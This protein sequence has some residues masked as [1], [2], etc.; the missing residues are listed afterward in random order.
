VDTKLGIIIPDQEI[1]SQLSRQHPYENWLKENRIRLRDIETPQRVPSSVGDQFEVF[2]NAF[3][4]NKDDFDQIV[5]PMAGTANEP[6]G[7]MGNDTPM[8]AFSDKPQRLFSYFRQL[9]AQ[10]TNPPIDPIREGLVMALTNYIGSV[11]KNM[12]TEGPSQ[13]RSIKFESPILNNTDLGKIKDFRREEF[14][15]ATIPMLFPA[16]SGGSGL[17]STVE[18]MCRAAEGAVDRNCNYIILS[19]RGVDANWVPVPSLLAVSSVHHHLIKAKKR[20]QV[21]LIVETGEAREVMHFALLLGYGASVINP[22]FCFS[23]IDE[24]VKKGSIETDYQTARENYIKSVDKG[25]LKIMSKMG[26]STLRSYHGSQQFEAVGISDEVIETC[27]TGTPSKVGGVGFDEIAREAQLFHDHAYKTDFLQQPL[28]SVGLMLTANMAKN[29]DGTLKPSACCSGQPRKMI[30]LNLR[31][32]VPRLM[33]IT[34]LH[35]S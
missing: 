2:K 34:E 4:Y 29:M 26:I 3:G 17:R 22:Y 30:T 20:M 14:T 21:G 31:S 19:D 1:K 23:V 18:E 6:V 9:F 33:R 15:H 8:A 7:S 27:F 35:C 12:L 32:L 16:N 5:A 28:I 13:C 25:I 10:V 24:L 11:S